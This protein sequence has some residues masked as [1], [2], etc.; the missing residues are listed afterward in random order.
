MIRKAITAALIAALLSTQLA[1]CGNEISKD[2]IPRL[3]VKQAHIPPK[4]L[5]AAARVQPGCR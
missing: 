1:G 5:R 2:E 3:S 4:A